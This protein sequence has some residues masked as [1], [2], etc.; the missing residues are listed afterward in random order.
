MSVTSLEKVQ[1]AA[2]GSAKSDEVTYE[3]PYRIKL[4][5][6]AEGPAT[7]FAY[8]RATPTA[9]WLGRTFSYGSDADASATCRE[10]SQPQR[11]KGSTEVWLFTA[12]YSTKL[13]GSDQKPDN[14]GD[15]SGWPP[16]WRPEVY[17]SWAQHEQPC[18]R[19]K[20]RGG[21]LHAPAKFTVGT[22]YIP[23]NS[24]FEI[25]DPPLTMDFSRATFR[26]RFWRE[27]YNQDV[28]TNLIDA[29]NNDDVTWQNYI[30][31]IGSC[32]RLTLKCANVP[33]HPKRESREHPTLGRVMLDYYEIDVELQ[34]KRDGWRDLVVDRG[35]RRKAEA[36]D[37]DGRGGTISLT[38]LIGG[39][40][41]NAAIVGIDGFPV[42]GPVLLNGAG[43]AK[44]AADRVPIYITWQKYQEIT[45]PADPYLS[46]F[47]Q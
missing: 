39:V 28:A 46:L 37:P 17:V 26:C 38:D 34:Y 19:A 16:D 45:Y 32:A 42:N 41:P 3:A 15:P 13:E 6:A 18:E 24:A 10:I 23:Q 43:E 20:Y 31:I 2:S 47:F 29:V 8:L 4:S 21:F 35:M 33:G 1:K 7:I 36:G 22:E 27:F 9:P 30:P 25:Y 12:K 14:N 5:S 11:E 44:D 40:P